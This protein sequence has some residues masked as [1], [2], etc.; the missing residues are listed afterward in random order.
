M[1]YDTFYNA[2]IIDFDFFEHL[3]SIITMQTN[4]RQSKYIVYVCDKDGGNINYT[5]QPQ[6]TV[7]RIMVHEFETLLL[8][9]F[10]RIKY[11]DNE[12]Y[13]YKSLNNLAIKKGKS[14]KVS[15]QKEI[16]INDLISP[17]WLID[18]HNKQMRVRYYGT[19]DDINDSDLY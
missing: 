10:Y 13:V 4:T 8:N 6:D 3:D 14:F 12:Y 16:S 9:D 2:K 11:K 7:L 19:F 17:Y 5:P 15:S 18:Y 1:V